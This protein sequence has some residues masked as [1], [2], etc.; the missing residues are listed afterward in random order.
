MVDIKDDEG[1][2]SL[3]VPLE[4]V[5]VEVEEHIAEDHEEAAPFFPR[6]I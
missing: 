3:V 5:G 4:E 2:L 6:I 1:E